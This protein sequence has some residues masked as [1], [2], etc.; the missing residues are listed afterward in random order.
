MNCPSIF[1]STRLRGREP[2]EISLKTL[3][4]IIN[5]RVIEI[6]EQAFLEIKNYGHEDPKKKL[7]AGI[8]LTRVCLVSSNCKH[9]S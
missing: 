5:A 7:I 3:S 2:K 6:I 9:S 8:V 4:K 1:H